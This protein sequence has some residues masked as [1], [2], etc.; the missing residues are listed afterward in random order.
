MNA[1]FTFNTAYPWLK[2]RTERENGER[3]IVTANLH[4]S[5][6]WVPAA[7]AYMVL[8]VHVDVVI[9]DRQ[10]EQDNRSASSAALA[11]AKLWIRACNVTV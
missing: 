9:R 8:A 7:C 6:W 4:H 3:I 2:P 11:D 5:F 1:V 10:I